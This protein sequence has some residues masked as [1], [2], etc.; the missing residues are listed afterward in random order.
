MRR[1]RPVLHCLVLLAL[2]STIFVAGRIEAATFIVGTGGA[3]THASLEL[4]VAAAAANGV[5]SDDIRLALPAATLGGRVDVNNHSL[6]LLGGY[7]SC[8]A[9]GPTGRTTLRR[10]GPSDAFWL[11]GGT[12]LRTF[13]L[14]N[15]D[16]VLG[17][18]AG[19]AMVL[20]DRLAVQL[21]NSE[22]SGGQA[23]DG[24]NV[25][26]SG[27]DVALSLTGSR[28]RDGSA[29]GT[30]AG[31]GFGGGIYCKQG[32]SIS[33]GA[34][35]SVH[36]NNAKIGGGGIYAEGCTVTVT[37]GGPRGDTAPFTGGIHSNTTLLGGGSGIYASAGA[38]VYLRG[39]SQTE[40]AYVTQNQS[41]PGGAGGGLYLVG[42]GTTATA[43]NAIIAN[44]AAALYGGGV[45]V[46]SGAA[47]SMDVDPSTCPSGR[48]CSELAGN[49]GAGY[50]GGI[51]VGTNGS[52]TIRKTRIHGNYSRTGLPGAAV[53][54]AGEGS[55]ILIEGCEIF[56]NK[57]PAGSGATQTTRIYVATTSAAT[58]AFSTLVETALDPGVSLLEIQPASTF[59]LLSSLVLAPKTFQAPAVANKVDCV[60]AQESAT[61]P[62]PPSHLAVTSDPSSLFVGFGSN[63]FRLSADSEARDFCNTQFYA[64][65]ESDMDNQPRGLDDGVANYLGPYD[66]G[67]DEAL[68]RCF[69]DGFEG[70]SSSQWSTAVP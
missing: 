37:S 13:E 36:G 12:A 63:D 4:A 65:A 62:W 46:A 29:A 35:S 1:A 8:A 61:F 15:I 14:R 28:I 38:T 52:A 50:G 64:P 59:K 69:I 17:A 27:A 48:R 45:Y 43:R 41:T 26:M 51:S 33:I 44:N 56:S 53:S 6:R 20:A 22:L 70:G 30:V 49:S 42:T 58:I 47:F 67:A 39:N 32:A 25:Y 23:L 5:E 24:G 66:L 2:G 54:G 18:G 31:T 57:P 9:A 68:P 19:R 40:L 10:D 3:C 60:I 11:H 21:V 55:Q 16:V 34:G 7:A